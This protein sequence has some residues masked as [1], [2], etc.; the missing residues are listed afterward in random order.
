[1]YPI[2]TA[3][4]AKV[5]SDTGDPFSP[6][7]AIEQPSSASVP[8]DRQS[9]IKLKNLDYKLGEFCVIIPSHWSA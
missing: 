3:M 6:E 5:G 2:G 4:H 1:M 9:R 7:A 8:F